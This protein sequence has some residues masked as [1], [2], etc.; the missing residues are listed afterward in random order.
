M[1]TVRY[2]EVEVQLVGT[3]GDAYAILGSVKKALK[4]AGVPAADVT[5][6][7]DEATSGDYDHLLQTTIKWVNVS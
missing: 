1:T 7:F 5:E 2:P 4:A 3:D 6:Y